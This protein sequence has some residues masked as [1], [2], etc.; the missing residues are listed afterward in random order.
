MDVS[1]AIKSPKLDL[2]SFG[3]WA[4]IGLVDMT[5]GFKFEM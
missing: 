1:P 2:T 5:D 4:G 3:H